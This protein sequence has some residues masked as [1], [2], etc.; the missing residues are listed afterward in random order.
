M[1]SGLGR[2]RRHIVISGVTSGLGRELVL[3]FCAAGHAVYGCGR[4]GDALDALR[5][6]CPA[7][8][9]TRLDV[10]DD[11]AVAAWAAACPEADLVVANAGVSPESGRSLAPWAVPRADFDATLDVNVKGV[12]TMVRHFVPAMVARGR[13]VFVAIS[14]G[15]G[16]SANPRHGA[17]CASKWAVEGLV[18]SVALA[19]PPPL[20]AVPLAPGVRG[21]RLSLSR[22]SASRAPDRRSQVVATEMQSGA[23]DGDARH[24]ATVAGPLLL[25]LGRADNGAS[26]SVPGFYTDKYKATWTVPDGA[27]LP[28]ELGHVF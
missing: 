7:A 23:G 8:A 21:P 12:A 26:L 25:G 15:L 6:A 9:L 18:K 20:A 28:P 4:R 10:C 22:P 19:L 2:E 1:T 11:A 5:A 17:Y 24:W 16:R 14:S 3:H 27:P 13:G